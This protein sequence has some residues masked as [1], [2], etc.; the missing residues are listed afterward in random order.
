MGIFKDGIK[1]QE[2]LKYDL[3]EEIIVFLGG[4]TFM[5]YNEIQLVVELLLYG[6]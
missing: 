5:I 2:I 6:F 1:N 3:R 4:V